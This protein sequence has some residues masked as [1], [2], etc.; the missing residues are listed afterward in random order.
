[1]VELRF[2]E[3]PSWRSRGQGG[4][5]DDLADTVAETAQACINEG[6]CITPLRQSSWMRSNRPL[7]PDE[8]WTPV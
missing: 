3:E 7:C 6:W 1:M 4:K 2:D 8:Q 5:S